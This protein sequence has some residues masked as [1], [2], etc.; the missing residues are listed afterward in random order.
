MPLQADEALVIL[1]R[2]SP[3]DANLIGFKRPDLMI[4]SRL[5]VAPPCVRPSVNMG[6]LMRSEDDLTYSYQ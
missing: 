6:G 2:I 1:K 5:A 4:I 3:E